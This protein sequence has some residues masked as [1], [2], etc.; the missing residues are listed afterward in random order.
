MISLLELAQRLL[1]SVL[2]LA[3]SWGLVYWVAGIVMRS[4][5]PQGRGI[6]R[7]LRWG[8]IVLV[9]VLAL[10]Q[11]YKVANSDAG[12]WVAPAVKPTAQHWR[13]G[14][15]DW[16]TVAI[17][18]GGYVTGIY[19]HPHQKDLVYMRTDVGGAYRWNPTDESWIPLTERFTIDQ[20]NYYGTESLALDPNDPDVV[21]MAAGKYLWEKGRLFKSSDRG[22]TWTPLDLE[23]PIG[24]AEEKRWAGE[25]LAV[26]P[27]D[28]QIVL[29]GS[30]QKEL[31]RSA[32]AGKTWKSV[33][34]FVAHSRQD[35]G[36]LAIAFDPKTAGVVYASAYEDAVYQSLDAGVTW[37]KLKESPSQVH[38]LTVAS[39]GVLYATASD[40]PQVSCYSAGK[41]RDI[42][43]QKFKTGYDG[44]AVN[45]ANPDQI[46]V[47]LAET[48]KS[49][50][51]QSLDGGAIW[52]AQNRKLND[53]V[54]WW[55]RPPLF[56]QPWIAAM[57]FDPQVPERV[58]LTE[59]TGV[60]RT[61]RASATPVVWTNYAKGHEEVV[62]GALASPPQGALLISGLYDVEGFYHGQGLDVF[63]EH[64]LGLQGA[65]RGYQLTKG[66][67][68][69]QQ[70]S[71]NMVR[72]GVRSQ[73]D[74][75]FA[76]TSQDG[77]RSWRQVPTFPK[78]AEPTRVAMSATEPN[79]IVVTLRD[80]QA[81]STLN[82]GKTWQPVVGLPKPG[83]EPRYVS[84][85]LAADRVD[86][87][88]FY[89]YENEKFY[90]SEDH[91][92]SFRV[93]N[94]SLPQ[95]NWAVV[96]ASPGVEHEVWI[97]MNEEG[98]FHSTDAGKTFAPV[99]TVEH[100]FLFAL[101][102]PPAESTIPALYLYGRITGKG[103]GIFRSL[104]RGKT[105]IK[106]NDAKTPIG[107]RP[108]VMEASQQ[109]YGLVFVGTG[110]RGV[111]YRHTG[112]L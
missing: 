67:D 15:K 23:L 74:Y 69:S 73:G 16:A 28:S 86:G 91:G 107:D 80:R 17:G 2:W 6:G 98:F 59:W 41:W 55:N 7:L 4:Q 90:R 52:Q 47:S 5:L 94:D 20:K 93:V 79:R 76:A 19:L 11:V 82:R 92:A 32:D 78:D 68:Y 49:K 95:A 110:G 84:P 56:T 99:K 60:W 25:R 109:E 3:G 12:Q 105:W 39:N 48:P 102:K 61:D 10:Q 31:W 24:G 97:G 40:N 35:I 8:T 111:Y 13:R 106:I 77:G 75:K 112:N 85:V 62:V 50:I 63:P 42:T 87:K 81:I 14:A 89:F 103:D 96:K 45:P 18:G 34:S 100:A 53:T 27:F 71:Q 66:M 36:I 65:Q 29:F 83:K 57:A 44:L 51:Y 38:R 104:D 64:K 37:H 101:G 22:N 26:N 72:I 58:W 21:Y 70:Q 9:L 30:R 46:W 88:T 108:L 1:P 54:P 43:P 33:K